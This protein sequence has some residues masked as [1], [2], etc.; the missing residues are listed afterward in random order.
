MF[1]QQFKNSGH[2]EK[3]RAE[4]LN[5]ESQDIKN[6]LAADKAGEKPIYRPKQWEAAARRLQKRQNR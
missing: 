4:I 1:M 2:G 5:Q 6:C 3:F